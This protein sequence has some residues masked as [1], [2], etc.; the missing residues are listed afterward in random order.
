MNFNG[1]TTIVAEK[2]WVFAYVILGITFYR[3]T[4]AQF[5]QI[6]TVLV[7]SVFALAGVDK[8][9]KKSTA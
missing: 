2:K 8:Y 4:D 5:M 3:C 9:V 6:L 1:I 7:P